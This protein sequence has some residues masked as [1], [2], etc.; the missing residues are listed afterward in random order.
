MKNKDTFDKEFDAAEKEAE[1]SLY[2]YVHTFSKPITYIG[3]T[4]TSLTFDFGK[5]TGRDALN[6]SAELERNG[7]MI[8]S[9]EF[10]TEYLIRVAAKACTENVGCDFL[11]SAPMRDFI[12]ITVR[13]R[14]F[15]L[16]AGSQT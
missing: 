5:L 7:R 2:T 12:K 11:N 13:A 6:I 8:I 9:P 10:N 1:N 16:N 14:S 4:Y 15:L 3:D